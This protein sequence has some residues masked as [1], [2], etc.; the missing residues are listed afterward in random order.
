RDGPCPAA[1][2][3]DAGVPVACRRQAR[4]GRPGA[5]VSGILAW[6]NLAEAAPWIALGLGVLAH[7]VA[8]APTVPLRARPG[9]ALVLG[10]LA[11]GDIVETNTGAWWRPWWLLAWKAICVVLLV[12]LVI[13]LIRGRRGER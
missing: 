8:R 2:A 13:R 5:G 3:P 1:P 6:I 7:A 12:A 4:T 11:T 10:A 9:L